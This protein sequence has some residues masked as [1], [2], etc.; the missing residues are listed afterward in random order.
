MQIKTMHDARAWVDA[1]AGKPSPEW[2]EIA[3]SVVARDCEPTPE[4]ERVL[5]YLRQLLPAPA[6]PLAA[7]RVVVTG[8]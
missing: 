7:R 1:W 6:A 5:V 2:V 3:V 4:T 8:R